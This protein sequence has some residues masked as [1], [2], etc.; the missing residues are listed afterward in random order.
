MGANPASISASP[1]RGQYTPNHADSR[2]PVVFANERRPGGRPP[3][4]SASR[5]ISLRMCYLTP[6]KIRRPDGTAC[7]AEP[8]W[9]PR[10]ARRIAANIAKLPELRHFYSDKT[11]L[12]PRLVQGPQNPRPHW[13]HRVESSI[14]L[15]V[16]GV[17][18][19]GIPAVN[20]LPVFYK[21]GI[22]SRMSVILETNTSHPGPAAERV[23]PAEGR[24]C[25]CVV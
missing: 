5:R 18:L 15:G 23:Y 25:K 13:P 12:G 24:Y 22:H 9:N 16:A 6:P 1:Q 11:T 4:A 7:V 2:I 10:E 14:G 17:G 19:N 8:P 20:D 3:L 21:H